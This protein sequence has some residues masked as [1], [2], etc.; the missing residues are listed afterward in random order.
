MFSKIVVKG[1]G[2]APLYKYLT[3]KD[4]D[5]KF[6]GDIEWNFA[7]FLINRDGEIVGRFPAKTDPMK[8]EVVTV[9]E[10]ELEVPAPDA[11][12]AEKSAQ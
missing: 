7:K 6:S 10:K 3:D 11:K 2:Q 4:T 8:T 9:I 1:E 5:P 12:T